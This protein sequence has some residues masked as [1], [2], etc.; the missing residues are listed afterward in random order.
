M[1]RQQ[2]TLYCSVLLYS[3][4]HTRKTT[5]T[6]TVQNIYSNVCTAVCMYWEYFSILYVTLGFVK[7]NES[8]SFSKK[9]A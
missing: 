1:L 5:G 8:H 2:P 3:Y 7:L 4:N 6:Q 9:M